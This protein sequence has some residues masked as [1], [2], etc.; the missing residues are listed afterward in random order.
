MELAAG[1]RFLKFNGKFIVVIVI[2]IIIL[3]KFVY[4]YISIIERNSSI[5]QQFTSFTW[6][7]WFSIF[8]G[9][10]P[11]TRPS[12]VDFAVLKGTP[13][14]FTNIYNINLTVAHAL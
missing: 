14:I 4:V 13:E 9:I 2:I 1:Y 5:Q 3:I 11:T 7:G 8:A 6:W 10:P 12:G